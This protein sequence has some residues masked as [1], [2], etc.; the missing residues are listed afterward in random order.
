MTDDR[1]YERATFAAGCFWGIEAAFR[2][3]KGVVSTAVGYTGGTT[4]EPSYE[5]VGAGNTGHAEAVEVTFD[6]VVVSYEQLLDLFW[7]IHD[8]TQLNRQGS[9]VGSNY[10][11]AIF[12][13]SPEQYATA[14][15]SK[16]KLEVTGAFRGH[17]ITTEIVPASTFWLAEEYHQ[18]YYE[19]CG[20]GYCAI[21]KNWE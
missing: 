20:Q 12:Y 13:H 18:Q 16:R 9:D 14:I 7:A 15:A 4:P 5:T 6:P 10:R 21:P 1:Q 17:N 19:K 8:P 2:R 3:I 11:S